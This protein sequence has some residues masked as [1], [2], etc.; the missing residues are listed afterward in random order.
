MIN[1]NG[2]V[3]GKTFAVE[4]EQQMASNIM[5][6][7]TYAVKGSQPKNTP[8]KNSTQPTVVPKVVDEKSTKP[9]SPS[10]VFKDHD[11]CTK[12]SSNEAN[13]IDVAAKTMG[14]QIT[15]NFSE[16]M[17]AIKVFTLILK[18]ILVSK[19]FSFLYNTDT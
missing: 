6:P 11:Y 18:L 17:P 2:F 9:A 4:T 10:A 8:T 5:R 3:K 12:V 16:G 1:H 15:S 19:S 14:D 7:K 13:V